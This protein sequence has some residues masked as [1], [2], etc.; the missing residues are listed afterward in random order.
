MKSSSTFLFLAVS[1]IASALVSRE[2][3]YSRKAPITIRCSRND[4]DDISSELYAAI[5]KQ[6]HGGEVWLLEGEKYVI[7]KRLDLSFLDDFALR[8]DGE[9]KVRLIDID[10]KLYSPILSSPMTSST[11]KAMR[12]TFTTLSRIALP[13]G[14]TIPLECSPRPGC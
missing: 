14:G 6:N 5:K 13:F 1:A 10:T 4:T 7:G 2:S 11:G 3:S 9:L 12:V 8:I